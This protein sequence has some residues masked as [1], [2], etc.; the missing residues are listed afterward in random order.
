MAFTLFQYRLP[1][2]GDLSDLNAY[3]NS[4]RVIAI[5]REIVSANG[6]PLLVFIVEVVSNARP[7]DIGSNSRTAR[8]DYREVL[9]EED[10][11]VFSSLRD[12]R[13][14][15]AEAEG[16]PVYNI[17][18]NAQLAEMVQSRCTSIEEIS[19]LDG[20]GKARVEK[21]ALAM[22]PHLREAFASESAS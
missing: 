5:Q 13:K 1:W 18:S 12:T 7:R 6:Q 22:L 19:K 16:V 15:L 14:M 2:D 10:F 11:A 9:G 4:N 20:I 8:V 3:L 17:F 21:Y